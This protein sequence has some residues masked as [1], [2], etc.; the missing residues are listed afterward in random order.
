MSA[1]PRFGVIVLA[2]GLSRRMGGPN[3]L[4]VDYEGKAL[5]NHALA[6]AAELAWEDRVAVT[7]RDALR[8]AELA[9][10]FG[11]RPVHNEA[12]ASGLGSS[13]A[14][15]VRALAP[16]LDALVVALG[17]MPLITAGEYRAL[18]Q[19][20]S[21]GV[22]AMPSYGGK[23]GHPVLFCASYRQALAALEGDEGAR[24]IIARSAS[25]VVEVAT[26][27][28]GVLRD[29]DFPEDFHAAAQNS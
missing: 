23:R 25:A 2:A 1:T 7:G 5:L 24:S 10:N 18:R 27:N 20:Y 9:A 13:L 6:A 14:E 28:A 3:K 19:A 15:G 17:D 4:L 12:Y 21:S 22:I 26:H 11:F 29:F 8:V 16:C